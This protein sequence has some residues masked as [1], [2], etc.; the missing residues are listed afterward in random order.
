MVDELAR[1]DLALD[2]FGAAGSSSSVPSPA[3]ASES[4]SASCSSVDD[5]AFDFLLFLRDEASAPDFFLRDE[6][7]EDMDLRFDPAAAEEAGEDD[8]PLVLVDLRF[9]EDEDERDLDE[10]L[11][12]EEERFCFLE[13]DDL[14]DDLDEDVV[15]VDGSVVELE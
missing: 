6:E 8:A 1:D 15:E 10:D 4:V 14:V 12:E 2:D 13:E 11:E 9:E 3:P 7:E 5:F